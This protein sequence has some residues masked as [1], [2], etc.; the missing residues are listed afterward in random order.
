MKKTLL[1]VAIAALSSQAA[2]AQDYQFEV[3]ANY[4]TGDFFGT[5][6]DGFGVNAEFHL[7]Q[8]DTSKG[9]LNEAA[10]L[11]KSSSASIA[12]ATVEEDIS[13]AESV[14][15]FGIGG[16]FVTEGNII[17][18]ANYSDLDYD[19]SFGF[20][21]GTYINDTLDVVVNYQTL[22][23][24]DESTLSANL[25]GLNDLAGEAAL[26]YD[27]S[28]AYLDV[29]DE[30][31]F[32]IGAGADYYFNNAFSAGAAFEYASVDN[33]DVTAVNVRADYFITP[34]ARVGITYTSLGSDADGDELGI[35]ASVRF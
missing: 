20:G 8:V 34:I 14:D 17:I 10:F 23:D 13:G 28:V 35:N 19:K 15:T 9:P 4:Q 11:D 7:D 5:D 32:S 16:R 22:D 30:N 31:G 29:V 21:V 25:H 12:W 33:A 18:E 26:A 2:L 3:G 6:Y 24:A 27:F 1:G